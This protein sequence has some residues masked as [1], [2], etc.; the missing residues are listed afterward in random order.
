MMNMNDLPMPEVKREK[1]LIELDK[2]ERMNFEKA[3]KDSND[4]LLDDVIENNNESISKVKVKV[5]LTN[6]G[7]KFK[8]LSQIVKE[9][10][11]SKDD[12]NIQSVELIHNQFRSSE[13]IDVSENFSELFDI[14]ISYLTKV[15]YNNQHEKNLPI[16]DVQEFIKII[17]SYKLKL[18][19]MN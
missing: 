8:K 9:S 1:K 18:K 15:L 11:V 6:K 5:K 3:L 12:Y 16:F 10:D 14:Q 19:V 7:N 4:K 2:E 17:K 13:T